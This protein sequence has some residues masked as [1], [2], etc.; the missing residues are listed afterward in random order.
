MNAKT[1]ELW[2]L[3]LKGV[4]EGEASLTSKEIKRLQSQP[5]LYH[6]AN[7]A[8]GIM[9]NLDDILEEKKLKRLFA[10]ASPQVLLTF[11]KKNER[12][13]RDFLHRM[14]GVEVPTEDSRFEQME[15]KGK[16][17][18]QALAAKQTA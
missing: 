5:E 12:A 1:K 8:G 14:R 15:R 11:R 16:L 7:E 18:S 3:L 10:R 13:K 17:I 9:L 4:T 6:S 2:L